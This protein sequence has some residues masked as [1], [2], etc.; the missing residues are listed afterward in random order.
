MREN[1]PEETEV[2]KL[3]V[4]GG[5]TYVLSLPKKWA[6]QMGLRKGSKLTLVRQN[7]GSLL[8]TPEELKKLEKPAEAIIEVAPT[9][10]PDSIIRKLV[11]TYLVGYNVIFIR[12]K[13]QRLDSAKRNAIKNFTRRML[14][15]TEIIADSP[16]ELIMKVL[17]SYPELSVQ[18]ALRRM[19]IITSSMHKDAIIAL[20]KLDGELARDVIAMD[21]EVDRFGLYIIR[22]LKAAVQDE[23]IIKEIGLSSGRDCLGYRLTTKAVERTADHAVVIAENVLMLKR[24]LETELFEQIDSMSASAISVFNEAIESL[25]KRDFQLANNT[26]QKAKQVALSEK[27]LVKPIL[28]RTDVGEVSSLSLIIE[29]I[30]RAAEYASD[31]AEIVLNLTVH[32]IITTQ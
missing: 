32:Q 31:I 24:P 13:N 11:S 30:R 4:T 8:V 25:F 5:S 14:V 20:K 19:C 22:Q 6:N 2:R 21:D 16:K 17:L 3:Q 10:D 7:D 27:E 1:A 15:G 23:K 12:T 9:D 28:K 18:S 29:S 26:V